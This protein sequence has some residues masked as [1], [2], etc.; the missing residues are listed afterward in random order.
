MAKAASPTTAP[1]PTCADEAPPVNM[2]GAPVIVEEGL[3][4]EPEA[5]EVMLALAAM[6]SITVPLFGYA[7]H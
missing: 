3:A 6:G 1:T 4:D 7:E 5:D 2:P